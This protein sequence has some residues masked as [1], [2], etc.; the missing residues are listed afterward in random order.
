MEHEL[1]ITGTCDY[2][3]IEPCV[4]SGGRVPF[5]K[6]LVGGCP[7]V[8][9]YAHTYPDVIPRRHGCAGFEGRYTHFRYPCSLELHQNGDGG[10][11]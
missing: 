4:G 2:A 1:T 3:T 6:G 7:V 8:Q 10:R 5:A 9:G 11:G